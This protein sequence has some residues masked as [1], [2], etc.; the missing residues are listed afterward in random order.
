[1]IEVVKVVCD[2]IGGFCISDIQNNQDLKVCFLKRYKQLTSIIDDVHQYATLFRHLFQMILYAEVYRCEGKLIDYQG[3]FQDHHVI[4][5]DLMK[6]DSLLQL[7]EEQ[8]C[9]L[10]GLLLGSMPISVQNAIVFELH[11]YYVKAM[12][13]SLECEDNAV[14][15]LC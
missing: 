6:D 10:G 4:F 1:M 3:I 7:K 13:E 2:D 15:N 14:F 11:C 12:E 5:V 9:F 8:I